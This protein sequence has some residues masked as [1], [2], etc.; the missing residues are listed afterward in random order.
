VLPIDQGLEIGFKTGA[1]LARMLKKQFD[2]PPLTGA[3]VPMNTSTS[4]AVQEGDR[5]LREKLFK[6]FGGHVVRYETSDMVAMQSANNAR[7]SELQEYSDYL[8]IDPTR[9][10]SSKYPTVLVRPSFN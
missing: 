1:I 3:K 6:F 4:Q 8:L 2:Q 5:L 10:R 7:G 9:S